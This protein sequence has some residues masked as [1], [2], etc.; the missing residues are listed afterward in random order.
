L[1]KRQRYKTKRQNPRRLAA[2]SIDVT[3]GST[4]KTLKVAMDTPNPLDWGL[5][6]IAKEDPALTDY[7]RYVAYER[8]ISLMKIVRKS[9]N[10]I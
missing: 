7:E 3:V 5:V 2:F 10:E 6:Q 1:K 8:E 9:L 4:E